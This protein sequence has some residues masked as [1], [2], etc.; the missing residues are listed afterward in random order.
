ML[1]RLGFLGA[2]ALIMVPFVPVMLV[3]VLMAFVA[4]LVGGDAD[5]V[6][7]NPVLGA[8]VDWPFSILNGR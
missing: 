7:L 2:F 5:E 6:L 4:W 8:L 3:T 1:R